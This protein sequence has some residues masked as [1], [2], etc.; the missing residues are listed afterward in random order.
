[1][2]APAAVESLAPAAAE[3]P[4]EPA[5]AQPA[6]AAASSASSAA[7]AAASANTDSKE[8]KADAEGDDSGDEDEDGAP[9]A[10]GAAGA[11]KK[12][13]KKKKVSSMK[14]A[15]CQDLAWSGHC[16]EHVRQALLVLRLPCWSLITSRL[17]RSITSR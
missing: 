5:V 11:D 9:D 12:K 3:L 8:N 10:D 13:K 2:S 15:S 1:M 7:P 6:A 17:A 16:A 14:T 4:V